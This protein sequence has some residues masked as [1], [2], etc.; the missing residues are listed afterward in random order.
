MAWLWLVGAAAATEVPVTAWQD[1]LARVVPAVVSVR[2]DATRAFDTNAASNSVATGFVV[3]AEQG[4]ILTNRHVVGPGPSVAE[5][6]FL[7]NEEV[8]V[9]PVYRDP[10]HDFG[11]YRFKNML[12]KV[13]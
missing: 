12:W 9:Q 4:L 3:D 1:T 10:V 2:T 7:D 11:I 13:G 5:V 8:D 6:V